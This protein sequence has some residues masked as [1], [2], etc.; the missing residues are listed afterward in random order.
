MIRGNKGLL[1]MFG[2]SNGTNDNDLCLAE[3]RN[4]C[5]GGEGG[6]RI[7]SSLSMRLKTSGL[8]GQ[9]GS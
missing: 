8:K 1:Q 7:K 3:M 4:R 5:A 2:I 6:R 9:L